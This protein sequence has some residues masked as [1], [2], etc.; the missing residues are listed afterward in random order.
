MGCSHFNIEEVVK[1]KD[2]TLENAF[3]ERLLKLIA[4][5]M[6]VVKLMSRKLAIDDPLLMGQLRAISISIESLTHNIK[7][8]F[9]YLAERTAGIELKFIMMPNGRILFSEDK[10]NDN[11][12]A[13]D[14][15]YV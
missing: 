1:T 6:M 15:L 7:V 3:V 5:D 9:T 12:E 13:P 11:D 4:T 14:D 10:D 2:E 8:W